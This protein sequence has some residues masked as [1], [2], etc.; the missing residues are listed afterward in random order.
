MANAPRHPFH[1]VDN[2]P[3]PLISSALAFSLTSGS[4]VYFYT[5]EASTML[6]SGAGLILLSFQWWRDISREATLLG[7]HSG[8]VELGIRWGMV[9]FICSEV[10]FFVS[11]F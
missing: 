9:L 10:F 2:S 3:W 5:A 6:L 7:L 8:V 1:L 4:V 11:F